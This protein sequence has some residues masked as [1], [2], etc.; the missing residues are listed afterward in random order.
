MAVR[1]NLKLPKTVNKLV[2]IVEVKYFLTRKQK[3]NLNLLR[4]NANVYYSV[5][6]IVYKLYKILLK[7]KS[8]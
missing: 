2:D 5:N 4:I 3:I 7:N 1:S 8:L 6:K